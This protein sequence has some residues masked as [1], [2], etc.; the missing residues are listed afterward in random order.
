MAPTMTVMLMS[1]AVH[2]YILE[3]GEAV[4]ALAY[5]VGEAELAI[6]FWH[7][8]EDDRWLE[9]RRSIKVKLRKFDRAAKT[10]TVYVT[11][12]DMPGTTLA[13]REL[14]LHFDQF[15]DDPIF[16]ELTKV[17]GLAFI[18][19]YHT[20]PYDWVD[21]DAEGEAAAAQSDIEL[22]DVHIP[23]DAHFLHRAGA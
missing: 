15:D 5:L 23:S 14:V 8:T 4:N 10:M 17:E 12:S 6:R 19:D 3:P 21:L 1:D 22:E 7:Y 11:N 16:V 18:P 9:H 13:N 20:Y 2:R